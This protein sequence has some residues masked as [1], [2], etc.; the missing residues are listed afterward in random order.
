MKEVKK[1]FIIKLLL[2]TAAAFFVFNFGVVAGVFNSVIDIMQ[3]IFIGIVFALILNAPLELFEST[4]FKRVKKEKTRFYLSAI[5]AIVLMLG[6]LVLFFA[7]IVPAGINSVQS[8][9]SQVNSA[10]GFEQ[11]A[12]GNAF[13]NFLVVQGK[14]LYQKLI[15]RLSDFT[16]KLVTIAQSVV[17]VIAN[18]VTG[19]FLA[20]L[21]IFNRNSLKAQ[22]AKVFDFMIKKPKLISL[23][24][25]SNIALKKFSRYLAGQLAEAFIFGTACY[26]FMSILRL[27]YAALI[28]LIMGFSNLIPIA[29]AYIGGALSTILIL[30]ISPLK[31]LIFVVFIIALQQLESVTTY[32]IVVG[33]YVGVNGF[34]ILLSIIIWGGLFGFWGLLLG[35]PLTA[36]LQE[37]L[38][39][40]IKEK[41]RIKLL[42][43]DNAELF[44]DQ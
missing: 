3:P 21:M 29:G 26:I 12:D 16:P 33:K 38:N 1:D 32:P 34:W 15:G 13:L 23:I 36:F 18:L 37:V 27:P 9:L 24:K 17:K 42:A 41:N 5:C 8:M 7:L 10:N 2:I 35:V 28:S 39:Q 44:T 31:A 20:I 43:K 25:V 14:K 19:M 6:F 40:Y 11:L 4:L 30:A 22:F